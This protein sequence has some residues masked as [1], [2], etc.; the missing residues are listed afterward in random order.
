MELGGVDLITSAN[1][2][3]LLEDKNDLSLVSFHQHPRVSIILPNDLKRAGWE[4]ML[5]DCFFRANVRRVREFVASHHGRLN[6]YS[7]R[8]DNFCTSDVVITSDTAM[9]YDTQEQNCPRHARG[10][11][12]RRD[13]HL[14]LVARAQGG[15]E[16]QANRTLPTRPWPAEFERTRI[17]ARLRPRSR[18]NLAAS[19]ARWHF[20]KW[21]RL[22]S[23][24]IMCGGETVGHPRNK[25]PGIDQE[26]VASTFSR[27]EGRRKCRRAGEEDRRAHCRRSPH[28]MT[29]PTRERRDG[30]LGCPAQR[31]QAST[32]AARYGR[33]I[34]TGYA[35]EGL[36][37]TDR[38]RGGPTMAVGPGKRGE[39]TW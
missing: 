25:P 27:R 26:P 35:K 37:S 22:N 4:V 29:S 7:E 38:A 5:E 32:W 24:N 11:L 14:R 36:R 18:W 13:G 9:Q 39:T 6:G 20:S 1:P 19:N 17:E 33:S 10:L 34:G 21:R 16:I 23:R 8:S 28:T 2:F 12:G 15:Y 31:G 30:R 3:P